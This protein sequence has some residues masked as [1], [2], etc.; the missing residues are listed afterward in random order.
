MDNKK[1]MD[2]L[3]DSDYEYTLVLSSDYMKEHEEWLAHANARPAAAPAETGS[4]QP[5]GTTHATDAQRLAGAVSAYEAQ[6]PAGDASAHEAQRPAGK[7]SASASVAA[8][9][10]PEEKKRAPVDP[11]AAMDYLYNEYEKMCL[12]EPTVLDLDDIYPHAYQWRSSDRYDTAKIEVLEEAL[13]H[14]LK[15]VDT[16]AYQRYVEAVKSRKFAPD[17]WD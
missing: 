4:Q 9:P 6:R 12:K 2:L 15:I 13:K 14:G 8:K 5:A 3:N 11:K 1:Y 7:D 16:A 10:Q 17:S